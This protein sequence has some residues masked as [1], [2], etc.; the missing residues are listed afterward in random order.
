[1]NHSF[2]TTARRISKA[3]R[4][5][6]QTESILWQNIGFA[7]GL[8]AVF[9][10]LT[11]LNG[12]TMWMVDFSDMGA[13]SACRVQ[14]PQNFEKRVMSAEFLLNSAALPQRTITHP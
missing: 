6:R 9:L 7:L 10:F 8:K 11:L 3:I 2:S 13:I 1:L 5:S 4:L 14:W 12:A